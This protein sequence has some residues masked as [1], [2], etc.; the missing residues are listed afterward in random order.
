MGKTYGKKPRIASRIR[1]TRNP[2]YRYARF[3]EREN[4][5]VSRLDRKT[6]HKEIET[7]NGSVIEVSR[8]DKGRVWT[9][10]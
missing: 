10:A 8:N 9:F 1:Y 4:R 7:S 3:L 6:S 2:G 5:L